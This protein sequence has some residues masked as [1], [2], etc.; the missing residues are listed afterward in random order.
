MLKNPPARTKKLT[1]HFPFAG[2]HANR[3]MLV[4][5]IRIKIRQEFIHSYESKLNFLTAA[6]LDKLE[7]SGNLIRV[8]TPASTI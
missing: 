1:M 2:P 3:G 4:F 7:R 8:I 5:C 6:T